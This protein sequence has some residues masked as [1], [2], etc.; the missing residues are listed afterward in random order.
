[1]LAHWW[2]NGSWHLQNLGTGPDRLAF[3]GLGVTSWDSARLDVF[4]IDAARHG[5]VHDYFNGS[6]HGPNHEDFPMGAAAAPTGAVAETAPV[7]V[8]ADPNPRS[9]PIPV[10]AKARAAD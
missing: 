9:T 8:M 4:S 1:V 10:D 7:T 6:W 3:T 5:L 2:Y